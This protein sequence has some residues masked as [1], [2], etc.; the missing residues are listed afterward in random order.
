MT[1]KLKNHYQDYL[2]AADWSQFTA[3]WVDHMFDLVDYGKINDVTFT[4]RIADVYGKKNLAPIQNVSNNKSRPEHTFVDRH[5]YSERGN[6]N[7]ILKTPATP[8]LSKPLYEADR[9]MLY[10]FS[11]DAFSDRQQ[12]FLYILQA[13]ATP[14]GIGGDIRS[15]AGGRA[16][17]LVW[18]DPYPRNYL[19]NSSDNMGQNNSPARYDDT[20]LRLPSPWG[21]ESGRSPTPSNPNPPQ[22]GINDRMRGYH[23]HKILYFKHLDN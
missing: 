21:W 6:E 20:G 9:K 17:A 19:V 13:E 2:T 10:S 22:L 5:W 8:V 16:V 1:E 4:N 18:R 14:P 3:N 12:L 23:E 11:M 15:L 7:E